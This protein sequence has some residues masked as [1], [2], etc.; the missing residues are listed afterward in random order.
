MDDTKCVYDVWDDFFI[1]SVGEADEASHGYGANTLSD[2]SYGEI[3]AEE[4][5]DQDNI[6]NAAYKKYI[7][8]EVIMDIP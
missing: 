5:S 3:M 1:G 6:K 4:N 2:E 8:S 7:D